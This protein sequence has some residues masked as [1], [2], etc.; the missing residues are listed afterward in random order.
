MGMRRKKIAINLYSNHYVAC[1]YEDSRKQV[2]LPY[3]CTTQGRWL[4]KK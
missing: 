4:P 3:F 2:N 1:Y